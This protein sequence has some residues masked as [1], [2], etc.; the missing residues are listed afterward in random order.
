MA[1]EAGIRGRPATFPIYEVKILA[2]VEA[3]GIGLL[4]LELLKIRLEE[5]ES[6]PA[7]AGAK[8][9]GREGAAIGD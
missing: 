6:W 9:S 8:Q 2:Q 7:D 1:L 4:V 5:I 3:E